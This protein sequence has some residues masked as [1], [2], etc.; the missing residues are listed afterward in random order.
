MDSIGET[1][2]QIKSLIILSIQEGGV[3]LASVVGAINNFPPLN[4]QKLSFGR[5]RA[6]DNRS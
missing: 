1:Q 3:G 6:A 2:E 5:S 4:R